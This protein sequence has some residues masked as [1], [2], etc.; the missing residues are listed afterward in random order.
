MGQ[1]LGVDFLPRHFYSEIPDIG[2]LKSTNHW[3]KPYSLCGVNGTS[4]DEQLRFVEAAVS[5]QVAAE[6]AQAG[7]HK[8]AC[9]ENGT[10]GYGPIEADLLYAVVASL[11]PRQ[12][13][14]VGCGVST[15]ICLAAAR[16]AGYQ[17][18]IT[19]IE[20]YPTA[21]LKKAAAEHKI[22]LIAKPVEEV[23]FGIVANLHDGDLFFIDST[24][25]LGPAGEVSRIILEMLPRLQAGVYVHFHDIYFPYDYYGGILTALTFSHESVLLQAFL[26]YNSRF[27]I[28]A[29]MS[30][31][32]YQKT[33]ELA[34]LFPHYK[35]RPNQ[36]GLAQGP[37]HFPSAIYLKVIGE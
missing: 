34:R 13:I 15:A 10:D 4:L 32:H 31:L 18:N 20:P 28:V 37:G 25:T 30:M 11:K 24:H 6:I 12:I 19:C 14:Q 2:R 33:D 8:A 1:W 29:S 35:P 21:F 5:P 22:T 23:D 36:D 26:A 9:L 3:R 27:A 17:P 7:I 16:A